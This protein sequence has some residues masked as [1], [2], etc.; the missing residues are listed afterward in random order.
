MC[1]GN[2]ADLP[3]PPMKMSSNA[4]VIVDRPKKV[5]AVEKLNASGLVRISKSK[6]PE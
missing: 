3:A 4:Q 6:V 5:A 1:N 2:I